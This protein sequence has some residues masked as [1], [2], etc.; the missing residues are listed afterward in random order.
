[1]E[2]LDVTPL[3]EIYNEDEFYEELDE[4][5]F[6]DFNIDTVVEDDNNTV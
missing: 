3:N 6:D 2:E 4:E 1:M 5:E